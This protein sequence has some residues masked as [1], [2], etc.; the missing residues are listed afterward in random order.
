[1]VYNSN[2]NVCVSLGDQKKNLQLKQVFA[3]PN[4]SLTL[5]F[6]TSLLPTFHKILLI[7]KL[8]IQILLTLAHKLV[9][10]FGWKKLLMK[11][12]SSSDHKDKIRADHWKFVSGLLRLLWLSFKAD[13]LRP[14]PT[15]HFREKW[16]TRNLSTGSGTTKIL[17]VFC[18]DLDIISNWLR[19]N[20]LFLH[21]T[22]TECVLFGTGIKL[23]NVDSFVITIDGHTINRVTEFKYLG[24]VLDERLSWNAHVKYVNARTG[25]RLGMLGRIRSNIT[26]SCAET[27]YKSFILPILDYCDTA[28]HGHVVVK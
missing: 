2:Y 11:T 14:V 18:K 4:E 12:Y 26:A 23:S 13:T 27:V 5:F 7:C 24:V 25:K 21:K 22:K 16:C 3:C 6:D 9:I 1:M 17:H 20:S 28:C 15:V 19:L 8:D 10:I